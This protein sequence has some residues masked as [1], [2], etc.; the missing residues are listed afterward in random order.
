MVLKHPCY[1]LG[2]SDLTNGAADCAAIRRLLRRL[3]A[4][5]TAGSRPRHSFSLSFKFPCVYLTAD[6]MKLQG[7]GGS[8]G[9]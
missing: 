2:G 4:L 7:I 1:V 9:S 6:A 8:G 3:R 5:R